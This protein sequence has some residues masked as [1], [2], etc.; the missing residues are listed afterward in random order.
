MA[1]FAGVLLLLGALVAQESKP[2]EKGLPASRGA[3]AAEA[4]EG[5][6][7]SRLGDP[8]P[9]LD[10]DLILYGP[11][12]FGAT[13]EDLVWDAHGRRLWFEWKR[14]NEKER[15][16]HVYDLETKVLTR[17][18]DDAEAPRLGVWSRDRRARA[19]T[20]RDSVW[21]EFFPSG[22]RK[23]LLRL[24]TTPSDLVFG[25]DGR[26]LLFSTEDG[27]FRMGIENGALE[28]LLHWKS[29]ARPKE[30]EKKPEGSE[31]PKADPVPPKDAKEFHE[32]EQLRLF[33]ALKEKKEA[34]DRRDARRKAR[35]KD[36]AEVPSYQVQEGFNRSS[37]WVSPSGRYAAVRLSKEAK[38]PRIADMPNYVTLDGFTKVEPTRAK[39]GEGSNDWWLELVDLTDGSITQINRVND[40]RS[41]LP[42]SLQWTPD[43]EH[44]LASA[45]TADDRNAWLVKV[46]LAS[47]ACTVLHHLEDPA[48]TLFESFPVEWLGGRNEGVFRSEQGGWQHLWKVDAAAG[49]V[50]ALTSGPMEFTSPQPTPDG[51]SIYATATLDSP[52]AREI[53]RVEVASGEM[54]RITKGGG[55]RSFELSPDGRTL[56]EVYSTPN[57][58]WELRLR[59]LLDGSV[60]EPI[61]DSPSP[62]FRSYEGWVVPEI[63]AVPASDG[64][65]VPARLYRPKEKKAGGPAVIFVHGAGY[66]QNVHQWWSRYEREYGFHHL[67]ASRGYTVLDIDY[68]GSSGYGRDWRTAIYGHM[69]G[70]DLEDQVDGA[71]YLVAEHG[72]DPKRIGIYGGSYGGFITLMALFTK[73]GVF[74]AGASLRPVTDWSH[75]NHGYTANILDTPLESPAHYERS[76]PIWW[77]EGL[78]D[79]LLICHGLLDDNVHAQDTVRLSQR[80]IE[81][82]KRNW[83]VAYYPLENHGFRDPAAWADEYRRILELF[84]R[85][86]RLRP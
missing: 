13:P 10:L 5:G 57:Q 66:L 73:P 37:V 67:L 42:H 32:R 43:G 86:L 14:W 79:H 3:A 38:K 70:R 30:E 63:V 45:N 80:L 16:L 51:D 8:M 48:W 1:R 25:P 75:Y 34:E 41:T 11:D 28:Q 26:D 6:L 50:V 27:V 47:G 7:R 59:N 71:R 74:A 61:T 55:G 84:E 39:V 62:A 78:Q 9:E 29:G 18:P 22:E 40:D 81:L 31:A 64:V 36:P 56:A 20:D 72:V 24:S 76:S 53:V 69:G 17:L 35:E 65:S 4:I 58:P 49:T 82:R 19:W 44:L 12:F 85:T 15:G 77:A 21:V 52:H 60:G 54:T 46:D 33:R 68:R 2:E 83:E 23:R